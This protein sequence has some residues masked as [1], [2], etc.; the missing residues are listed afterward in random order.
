MSPID[1]R[2]L[3]GRVIR[4]LSGKRLSRRRFS[5]RR[6]SS[7]NVMIALV[8]CCGLILPQSV[9]EAG[10]PV[11]KT[12]VSAKAPTVMD[13]SLAADGSIVGQLINN[14][15]RALK[16]EVVSFWQGNSK[17][18]TIKVGPKG[19]FVVRNLKGGLYRVATKNG[20]A[21]V[22]VWSNKTAPPSAK[23]KLT[24]VAGQQ[25]VRGQAIMSPYGPDIIT[26]T[27]IALAVTGVTLGAVALN[28]VNNV[29]DDYDDHVKK[30]H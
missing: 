25:V 22:R 13:V 6:P 17:I 29:E 21:L 5:M 2:L 30:S 24:L 12:P 4:G 8:A 11:P 28:K 23:T 3:S 27:T 1:P 15:G 7:L 16:D 18:A 26:L 10:T 14:Q 20:Q 9:L 19:T